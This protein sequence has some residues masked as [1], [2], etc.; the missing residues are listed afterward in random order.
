MEGE[1]LDKITKDNMDYRK[2]TKDNIQSIYK[3][4][5]R[6]SRFFSIPFDYF[7]RGTLEDDG[8]DPILSLILF[9]TETNKPIAAFIVVKRNKIN[10][11]YC[12][13]K[14]C[15]V[16]EQYRRQGFGSEMLFEFI[17]RAK[18]KG[19]T[20]VIYGPSVPDYWQS[21]VDIR[22][23]SLYFFLKK[24]GFKSQKAIFNLTVSLDIV[25]REPASKKDGYNYERVQPDDFDKTFDFVK[26][27]FPEG[28]WPEEVRYSFKFDP[29]TTF[30]VKNAKNEIVGW[31][32]HSQFFPGSF[33]PTGV[34][35]SLRGKGIG[36]ELFLWT[37]WDIKQNGLDTCEIMWV[38]GDTVKFYSKVIGAYI[39]PIFYPMYKK[40]K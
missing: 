37:L 38:T 7:Q 29:P 39:S 35:E 9:N 1:N 22:N 14:G 3:L 34:L 40:I 15:V 12:F 6:N 25:K 24:H 2:L 5:E 10:E 21:G 20:Q 33:G 11:H 31:A 28:T 19:I 17:K 32:T 36:T 4:F 16:D 23:T 26:Q 13:F 18:E 8:F 27:H 30:I